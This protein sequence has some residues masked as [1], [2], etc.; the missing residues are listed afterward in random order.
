VEHCENCGRQGQE[1]E[2]HDGYSGCCN[3]RMCYGDGDGCCFA[4]GE[5]F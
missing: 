5:E 3:E 4:K 1:A 2:A